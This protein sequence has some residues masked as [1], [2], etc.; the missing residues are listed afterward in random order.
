MNLFTYTALLIQNG[1]NVAAADAQFKAQRTGPNGSLNQAFVDQILAARRHH[2]PTPPIRCSTSRSSQPIN[3]RDANI[4]GFEF[5]GQYFFG[6]TGFGVAASYTMVNGDVDIDIGADPSIDQFALLGLS[7]S[8][9][10]TLIYDKN[11]ISA[12]LAYNWRDKFLTRDQPRRHRSQPGVHRR[13]S[14]R[15]TSTSATTSPTTSR[16]RSKAST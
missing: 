2:R 7:D 5:A 12:R 11:G 16:C 14:A 13:P 1:G 6:D 10:V 15:S 8:A 9:N 3:N 4:Y